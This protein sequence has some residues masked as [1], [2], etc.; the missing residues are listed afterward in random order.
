MNAALRL[1][2]HKRA[3]RERL[4]QVRLESIHSTWQHCPSETQSCMVQ[5]V[6]RAAGPGKH[7]HQRRQIAADGLN[8]YSSLA[9][10][11]IKVY[12]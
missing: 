1:E 7:R 6:I 3:A 4:P 8:G 11:S 12:S 10:L 2:M 9:V 5:C